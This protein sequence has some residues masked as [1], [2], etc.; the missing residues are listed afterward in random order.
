MRPTALQSE[1]AFSG[2]PSNWYCMVNFPDPE[3]PL[4]LY[5]CASSKTVRRVR[6]CMT[7]AALTCCCMESVASHTYNI[8]AGKKVSG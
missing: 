7:W 4:P 2:S 8:K 5:V 3:S 1:A 6:S